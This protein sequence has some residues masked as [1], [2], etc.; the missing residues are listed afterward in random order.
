MAPRARI[1][2][3]VGGMLVGCAVLMIALVPVAAAAEPTQ[4]KPL[5][6]CS[7]RDSFGGTQDVGENRLSVER[8]APNDPRYRLVAHWDRWDGKP[9]AEGAAQDLGRPI[10]WDSPRLVIRLREENLVGVTLLTQEQAVEGAIYSGTDMPG[11]AQATVD[12]E[13]AMLRA[14]GVGPVFVKVRVERPGLDLATCWAELPT[15][16]NLDGAAQSGRLLDLVAAP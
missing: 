5:A 8:V 15:A 2:K 14:R 16:R 3:L 13:P 9:I 6:E 4:T 10:D 12:L 7:D 1:G 11:G